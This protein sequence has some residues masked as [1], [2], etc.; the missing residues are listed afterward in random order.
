MG[1]SSILELIGKNCTRKYVLYFNYFVVGLIMETF[2]QPNNKTIK[3]IYCW[4]PNDSD[5][6][7]NHTF[8]ITRQIM[9]L[10]IYYIMPLIF[11]SIFYILIAKHLFQTKSVILTQLSTQPLIKEVTNT[12]RGQIAF[13]SAN[14]TSNNTLLYNSKIPEEHRQ[15][16]LNNNNCKKKIQSRSLPLNNEDRMSARNSSPVVLSTIS[17]SSSP[18]TNNVRQN[19]NL[20][21]GNSTINNNITIHTLYQDVKTKKQLRARHKVAKTVLFLCSVF[22]VCWLPKQIHDLYW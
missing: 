6:L 13:K 2:N 8:M 1:L 3:L 17:P 10:I 22:F 15:N 7:A 14:Q 18:L 16:E 20:S 12:K 11:V 4:S 9:R 19:R 21:V 5:L